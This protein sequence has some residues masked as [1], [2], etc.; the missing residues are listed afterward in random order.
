MPNPFP[1][2]ATMLK[3]RDAVRNLPP[4][5]PPSNGREGLRLDLNENTAGCSPRVLARL[6]ELTPQEVASYAERE[7]AEA[8][9]AEFLRIQ[10]GEMLLTNGVDEA[11]HLLCETFLEPQ[12]EVLIPVPTFV[13]YEISAAATG[14]R[15]IAVP[16]DDSFRF[17]AARLLS[18]IT[19]RTR[20][21]LVANPNNPTGAVARPDDLLEIARC[22]PNAAIL[23]D[24]AYFEFYGKTLLP[25]W[26]NLP[27]LFLARTFSK[28]YGLAGLRVGVLAGNEAQI[29]MVRRAVT[30]FNVNSVALACVPAALADQ[31]FVRQYVAQVVAGRERLQEQLRCCG[32]VSWPSQGNFVLARVGSQHLALIQG[33]RQRGILVRDRSRDHG[34]EG[35]VRITIG[36]EEQTD[37][38]LAAIRAVLD[39]IGVGSAT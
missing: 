14:A 34:C 4:Y 13:M 22:A 15:V 37:S 16:A 24:E 33:L 30:P 25:E 5:D 6:R 12:D 19:S 35:C 9:V 38:L 21:I 27:N 28:A 1:S 17:P 18:H 23:I 20:L 7:P 2:G 3:A 31:E 8:A 10:S 39:Q 32:I 26:R 29:Q 36:T 11:I